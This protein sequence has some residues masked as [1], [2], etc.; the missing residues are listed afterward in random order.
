MREL[1]ILQII[2]VFFLIGIRI[3]HY[4]K[5][6]FSSRLLLEKEMLLKGKVMYVSKS[7]SYIRAY[8]TIHLKL[9][10][11]ETLAVIQSYRNTLR[12][13]LQKIPKVGESIYLYC[14]KKKF[15]I[16]QQQEKNNVKGLR[17]EEIA[18]SVYGIGLNKPCS[19]AKR[20][21]DLL[22]D[23]ESGKGFLLL[24]A[25]GILIYIGITLG[26]SEPVLYQDLNYF[27]FLLLVVV[28]INFFLVSI[29]L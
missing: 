9:D 7:S 29:L 27:N 22:F 23:Y 11:G 14:S 18:L 28:F 4:Y 2:I 1:I 16:K 19:R 6:I 21:Y 26:K 24:L 3:Y 5:I 12:W 10:E 13:W 8:L 17:G 15:D 25:A 20:I